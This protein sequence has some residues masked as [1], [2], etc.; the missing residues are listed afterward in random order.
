M[1]LTVLNDQ[2]CLGVS[3][4]L[5]YSVFPEPNT[6]IITDA[7]G[8]LNSTP[9]DAYQWYLNGEEIPGATD[10]FY[11]PMENGDF[12]VMITAPSTCTAISD[13]YTLLNVGLSDV[14]ASGFRVWPN[15]AEG[16][17]FVSVGGMVRMTYE[18]NDADGRT[19]KRGAL[20]ANGTSLIDVSGLVPGAYVMRLSDGQHAAVRTVVVK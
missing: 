10:Q 1:T 11:T 17:V 19:V 4:T 16:T 9:A 13:P 8:V 12:T 18:L 2:G 3:D 14:G 20:R 15:P 5:F 7:G 6:P